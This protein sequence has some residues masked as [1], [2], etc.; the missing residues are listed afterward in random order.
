MESQVIQLCSS[1]L[2]QR[3]VDE[4]RVNKQGKRMKTR[5][6]HSKKRDISQLNSVFDQWDS[7]LHEIKT[8]N[9]LGNVFLKNQTEKIKVS[10]TFDLDQLPVNFGQSLVSSDESFFGLDPLNQA[11]GQLVQLIH[12]VGGHKFRQKTIQREPKITNY[13]Y[14]SQDSSKW[15]KSSGICKRVQ[16]QM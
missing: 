9:R 2:S 12:E 8:F 14:C 1:C 5:F 15:T 13:Y 4:F 10:H 16:H 3:P 11:I 6:R 7:F